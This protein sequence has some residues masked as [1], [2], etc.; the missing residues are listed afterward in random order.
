MDKWIVEN[1]KLVR[2][3]WARQPT[4]VDQISFRPAT[5]NYETLR[6]PPTCAIFV[7]RRFT[8]DSMFEVAAHG[9]TT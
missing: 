6:T 8:I 9:V 3:V 1:P 2:F 4:V 5:T 7:V